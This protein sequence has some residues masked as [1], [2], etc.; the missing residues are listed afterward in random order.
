MLSIFVTSTSPTNSLNN[1]CF[2]I[3]VSEISGSV[4]GFDAIFPERESV[5]VKTL[6][7]SVSKA[8]LPPG[9]A[10][11]IGV[12]PLKIETILVLTDLYKI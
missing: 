5:F 11:L 8:K 1:S 9:V 4:F 10:F 12:V 2:N 7:N 3:T 6:S